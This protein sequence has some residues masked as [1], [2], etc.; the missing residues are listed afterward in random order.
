[1]T[2]YSTDSETAQFLCNA[3]GGAITPSD[4]QNK[5]PPP[6]EFPQAPRYSYPQYPPAPYNYAPWAPKVP[7][8]PPAPLNYRPPLYEPRQAHPMDLASNAPMQLNHIPNPSSTNLP[9]IGQDN[10]SMSH[11]P[12]KTP[13]T[14]VLGEKFSELSNLL[15]GYHT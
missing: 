15:K 2:V 11:N 3:A 8:A 14:S 6:H 5:P 12:P 9:S 13:S 7:T 10:V 1:M 4:R